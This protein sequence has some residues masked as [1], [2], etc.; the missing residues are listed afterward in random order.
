M[1]RMGP[2]L[3]VWPPSVRK[4]CQRP[5]SFVNGVP[6]EATSVSDGA[7]VI[8]VEEVTSFR[9]GPKDGSY[10]ISFSDES[11]AELI[12]SYLR[13]ATKKILFG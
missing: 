6:S 7:D 4:R 10:Y 12:G 11:F 13:P 3:S 9:I 2:N 5:F 8:G 1:P